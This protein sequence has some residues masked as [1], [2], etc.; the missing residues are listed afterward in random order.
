MKKRRDY[1]SG[2]LMLI[3]IVIVFH[4]FIHL[5]LINQEKNV[6]TSSLSGLS[7]SED[8]VGENLESKDI[9]KSVSRVS[10]VFEWFIAAIFVLFLHFNKKVASDDEL[11][12]VKVLIEKR[13]DLYTLVN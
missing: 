2:A 5:T 10:V 6:N 9:W 13:K 12:K 3:L 8:K 7:I 1:K 11:S 4:T